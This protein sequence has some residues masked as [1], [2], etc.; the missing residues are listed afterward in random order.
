[1]DKLIILPSWCESLG[2]MTVSLSMTI[3]GFAQ[4]QSLDR[5]RV[6]VR[7]DSLLESYLQ[8]AGQRDCLESIT[9]VDGLEFYQRGLNWVARQPQDY[10]LLLENCTNRYLLPILGRNIPRLKLSRRRIYHFFRD[11]A[12]SHNFWGQLLRQAVFTGLAPGAICNSKFTAQSLVKHLPLKIQGVLYPPVD[13]ERFHP[14][15]TKTTAPPELQPIL[16]SGAKIMLTPTRISEPGHINDKNLRGLILVLSKLK[17]LGYHY[18]SVIIGQDYSPGKFNTCA[19]QEFARE[20][21]VSERLTI[22]PPTFAIENYYQYADVVVTLS[23]REP[24]GRTVVE[25]I[26]CGVPVVGSK[27]GG[28]GEILGNFAPQ[29]TVDPDDSMAVAQTIINLAQDS[30]VPLLQTQGQQ[31]VASHCSPVEYVKK[32]MAI[33]NLDFPVTRQELNDEVEVASRKKVIG[34]R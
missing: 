19:L 26:A 34:N 14:A 21:G 18:H 3:A 6:L 23:P 27:T 25:A 30:N 7:A 10:P 22:L 20:L 11:L 9:A 33:V 29:W 15:L 12:Y 17:Q 16:N 8:Q 1:M 2:G 5:I 4:L 13:Q 24:F 28:I 31:W 32:L